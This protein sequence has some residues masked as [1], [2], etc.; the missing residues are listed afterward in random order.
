VSEARERLSFDDN[1][2]RLR[3]RI[4]ASKFPFC[5]F[6]LA[7]GLDQHLV[8]HGKSTETIT[9]MAATVNTPF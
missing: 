7:A 6:A 2:L 3:I 1:R 8:I 9:P 4:P 5:S